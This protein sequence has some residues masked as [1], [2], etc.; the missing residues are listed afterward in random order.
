M[1]QDKLSSQ[2]PV[3]KSQNKGR[4]P[5]RSG[6]CI[7]LFFCILGITGC[8]MDYNF[9][10][11]ELEMPSRSLLPGDRAPLPGDAIYKKERFT[12]NPPSNTMGWL[13]VDS[14]ENAVTLFSSRHSTWISGGY[15]P[16][17]GDPFSDEETLVKK[18]REGEV[19]LLTKKETSKTITSPPLNLGFENLEGEMNFSSRRINE[20]TYYVT[21]YSADRRE[22]DTLTRQRIFVY[23]LPDKNLQ[24]IYVIS[25]VIPK[26]KADEEIYSKRTLLSLVTSFIIKQEDN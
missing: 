23:I 19:A 6:T 2:N 16:L 7:L 4:G 11:P 8:M 14:S 21:D 1:K 15:L 25:M 3:T 17:S 5:S 13:L 18:F 10:A 22:E 9:L 24:G 12:F 26:G 20:R